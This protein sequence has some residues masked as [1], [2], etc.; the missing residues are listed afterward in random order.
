M[1][2]SL[3]VFHRWLALAASVFILVVAVTGSALVFEGAI[4]RGLNPQLW[5]VTPGTQPLSLDTLA[6]R[7]KAVSGDSISALTLANV[8]DR[9][10]VARTRA[11]QIFLDP[12]TGRV[13]GTRATAD[14]NKSL[15]RRL[16][17][18]HTSLLADKAG[19]ATRA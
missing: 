4:D 14:F 2:A 18:L 1:R 5:R 11:R 16:H 13:L 12:Y 7:A 17:L 15:P 10:W 3:L 19:G 6:A 8:S 9:A